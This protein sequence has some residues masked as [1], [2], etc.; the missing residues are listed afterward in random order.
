MITFLEFLRGRLQQSGFATEDVLAS[1]LPLV[2]RVIATHEAGNVAPLESVERLLVT[3]DSTGA[4]IVLT[5]E[6]HEELAQRMRFR[7]LNRI[8]RQHDLAVDVIGRRTVVHDTD[9]GLQQH[10]LDVSTAPADD[11]GPDPEAAHRI[12]YR[13]WEHEIGH[14][15]P[16]SDVYTL[17]LILVSLACGLDLT[18]EDDFRRFVEHRRNL[19]RIN[20]DL[21]P[22]LA[23]SIVLM[24]ELNRHDRPQ[25]LPALLASIENYRDQDV[26]FETDLASE[27]ALA[28]QNPSGRRQV[29]LKKLQ[30]RLFEINRR[31]RLLQFR[32][33]L[34]TLNLTH[35]SIPVA[36]DAASI[37]EDEVLTWGGRF[38]KD[39]LKQKP[40]WLNRFLNFQ[41][42][43]YVPGQLDRLRAEARRDQTE[44]GFAQLKL[45][46]C[47]LRWSDLK[48]SPVERY[49]SPL[50][51]LPAQLDV[52]RGIH[53]RYSL[54]VVDDQAEVNPVIRHLFRQL[55]DIDLPA[56]VAAD[57]AG[58]T[59]FYESLRERIQQSDKSVELARI[60]RPRIELIHEQAK[61]RLAQFQ[62]R[63]RRSGRGVRQFRDLN[64]SYD[65]ISYQPLGLQ[66]FEN[67]IVPAKTRLESIVTDQTPHK[68]HFTPDE[69]SGDQPANDDVAADDVD[70]GAGGASPPEALAATDGG[71]KDSDAPDGDAT[72]GQAA[73]VVAEK[74]FYSLKNEADDNPYHWEFDL[75][76]VTL[77]NLRYRRMSLVN[78]YTQLV[79]DNT[80]NPAFEAAFSIAPIDRS[81]ESSEPPPLEDRFH[82]VSCDPTQ[83]AAVHRARTGES[84]IIQGPPGTGKS[85]TI[86]NLIADFVVRGQRILF[87]CEK[88]AAIDVV[89]HRLRQ[90]GLGSLCCLIHDSQADK[91][92]FVMDL[93]KAYEGLLE[94]ADAAPV[95]R[96]S[97]VADVARALSPVADFHRVMTTELPG[98]TL[99]VRQLLGRLIREHRNDRPPAVAGLSEAQAERLPDYGQVAAAAAAL[100]EFDERLRRLQSDGVLSHHPLALLHE[101]V[102]EVERPTEFVQ[103]LLQECLAGEEGPL[104]QLASRL[105]QLSSVRA[106]FLTWRGVKES[107]AF[108]QSLRFLAVADQLDL[109][110]TQGTAEKTL[111]RC[112][113]RLEKCSQSIAAA[114]KKTK[115]WVEKL[116]SEDTS[117]ALDQA[118]QLEG[119]LT[120]FVRP[121]YWRLRK[122]MQ[123]A[124]NFSAHRVQPSWTQVLTQLDQEHERRADRYEA[125]HEIA[126]ELHI[127]GDFDE[128]HQQLLDLREDLR[129]TPA[130]LRQLLDELRQDDD[131]GEKVVSLADLDGDLAALETQLNQ[132]LQE[133][134]HLSPAEIIARL[135][136]MEQALPAVADF[137]HGVAALQ[138]VPSDVTKA[139]R[140]LPL[141]VEELQTAAAERTLENLFRIEREADSYDAARRSRQLDDVAQAWGRLERINAQTVRQAVRERFLENV[142]LCTTPAAQLT[143]EQKQLK[144]IYSAGRRG[145][146]HEFGKSM[147]YKAIREI[148]TGE[149]GRV[150]QDFKPIWLMSPLSVSDT[151]PLHADGFDVV[152]FDEASQITLEEAIP[153]LFRAAQTI[154]VGD[155]M[156]LPPTSFFASRR[157]EDEELTFEEDG[158][159]VQFDL[160]SNSFLN[161]SSRNLPTRTLGWHYRSRSES[162]ISFSNHAFYRGRLLTV[163]EESLLTQPRTDLVATTAADGDVLAVEVLQRPL[164][165]HFCEHGVYE[166]RRNRAEADYIAR[167]VR[168]LLTTDAE[169]TI[170][171]V[172]FSEAQQ[173]EIH[174]G[175]RSLAD[176]DPE[177][178]DLLEAAWE[179]EVDGQFA[180]L[181]VKNLENIQGDERDVIIMSVCYGP[182]PDG[183]IR[184][185]FGPINMAGGEKRLNVAFSRARH[186]MALVSS[187]RSS[188]I[189][190]DYNDGANCLKNYLRYAEECSRG[191]TQAAGQ[192]LQSLSGLVSG[193]QQQ[194][195]LDPLVSALGGALQQLGLQVDYNIGQ[196]QF[197]CDLAVYRAGDTTY[198]LGILCDTDRWYQQTDLLERELMR[199]NLLQAFGWEVEVVLARDWYND[200][201]AVLQRLQERLP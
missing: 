76:R 101:H 106:A 92:Q 176:Q 117:I 107:V 148:A 159:V 9:E 60:D 45:I 11:D 174:R 195:S 35:A 75:C 152:I 123:A 64:Y 145:L 189:T 28:G 143:A 29:V 115:H 62:R 30:E 153:S 173:E 43:V 18:R 141:S 184:M 16:A 200:R 129:Q 46:V 108:A 90:Q 58:I 187:L 6:E 166:K 14:H 96:D 177:F 147:R 132:I 93:R 55:Y 41:E 12:G 49:E 73:A 31:N 168:G 99:T 144:K 81:D 154:V 56:Q 192:V 10:T 198:R 88:R 100:Q 53:D 133:Y 162:L 74:S 193:E 157:D 37:R 59:A 110:Q 188:A 8:L 138:G 109:T 77:A 142:R 156:Q 95:D 185:N 167:L 86:T 78:D 19:F 69:G 68:R 21:H 25:D 71:A 33:T 26:D 65:R 91:K 40:V 17:G 50:L 130:P 66:I 44:Y 34:Q 169:R 165:F 23:R 119:S 139:L 175:L 158:Q 48:A 171:I 2:R 7:R 134:Q 197:R 151:L 79:D 120:R 82:V 54:K 103:S 47:F 128:F 122:L 13:C 201:Q 36:F 97:C 181:L 24:T 85:Q 196:S 161:H 172:A 4:T 94:E 113:K 149:T 89:F 111:Q 199:P 42:A 140:T 38:Q 112:L 61:R 3:A 186:H 83:T 135:Q 52:R 146:E 57:A 137:L 127:D 126:A 136:G 180:G 20:R 178:A 114:E 183:R 190:N 155:E 164:S 87:V 194:E 67:Y 27:Q 116:S 39:T 51:L 102:G 63:A 105:E 160:N 80:S 170:G 104:R 182:D 191:N 32:T 70:Q 124:Y 22:V 84:Y 15:D 72:D 1:F 98:A 150:V 125:A 179:R 131:G 5:Y 118:R 163:P 121:A